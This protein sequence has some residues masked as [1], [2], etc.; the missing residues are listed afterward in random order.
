MIALTSSPDL[1]KKHANNWT[2]TV[3]GYLLTAIITVL[4]LQFIVVS[5]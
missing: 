3:I 4:N 1:M 2:T 5:F